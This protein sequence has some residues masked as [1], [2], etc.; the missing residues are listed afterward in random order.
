LGIKLKRR[1]IVTEVNDWEFKH[2]IRQGYVKRGKKYLPEG[3][4]GIKM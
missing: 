4:N 1:L 2:L 3:K